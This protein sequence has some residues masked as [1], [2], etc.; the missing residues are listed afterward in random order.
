MVFYL[1]L[2]P[3]FLFVTSGNHKKLWLIDGCNLMGYKGV[4]RSREILI[5]KLSQIN[6]RDT[7][8]IVVFDGKPGDES[9][10]VHRNEKENFVVVKTTGMVT[11][12]DFIL[13]EIMEITQ[14]PEKKYM[15][16]RLVSG[17]IGL[18]QLC[19]A[20]RKAGTDVINPATFWKRYRPR[21]ANLK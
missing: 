13:Q 9:I 5:D 4:P 7:E 20:Y 3:F 19:L 6:T 16:I 11:A 10:S 14:D 12:D 8:V 17:D 21:L 2:V 18:R 1:F 15:T